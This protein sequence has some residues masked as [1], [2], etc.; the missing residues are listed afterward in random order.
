MATTRKKKEPGAVI[1]PVVV[2]GNHLTVT[3]HP[4]GRTMLEW[5]DTALLE[6][7]RAAL[8]SVTPASK[9][10]DKFNFSEPK[11]IVTKDG[12]LSLEVTVTKKE[13]NGNK[14]RKTRKSK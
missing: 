1:D 7:V 3:T 4:D 5:D 12:N 8:A 11:K 10:S 14:T 6:E 9:A 13:T 2:K